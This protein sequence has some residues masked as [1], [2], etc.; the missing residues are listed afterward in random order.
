[1]WVV[2]ELT[3]DILSTKYK[4]KSTL[5]LTLY[6]IWLKLKVC[7]DLTIT[8]YGVDSVKD[9][10][11]DTLYKSSQSVNA[12]KFHMKKELVKNELKIRNNTS[13]F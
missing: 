7:G 1:M 13:S 5:C 11:S 6:D 3:F 10:Y 4:W 12:K 9:H 8:I 2:Y